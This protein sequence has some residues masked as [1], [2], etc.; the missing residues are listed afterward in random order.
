MAALGTP[1]R[2]LDDARRIRLSRGKLLCHN[3]EYVRCRRRPKHLLV[4][5]L[6]NQGRRQVW[7]IFGQGQKQR[8]WN[9]FPS[10][11]GAEQLTHMLRS[12]GS[13]R[14]KV[15]I[16]VRASDAVAGLSS[17]GELAGSP[18]CSLV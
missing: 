17:R 3:L 14:L 1:H 9:A 11:N 15:D 10:L 18:G 5:I 12:R 13:R 16:S 6:P 8:G 4:A 2:S 7:R